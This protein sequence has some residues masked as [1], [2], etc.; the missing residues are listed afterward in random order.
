M[1]SLVEPSYEYQVG[2][3]LRVSAPSYIGRQT[4]EELYQALR[5]GEFCCVFNSRQMG[6]S[7]LRVQVKH[8]L[9]QDGVCCS[10]VDV[11]SIGSEAIAPQQWYRGLI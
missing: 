9:E 1:T 6:K 5:A 7:S 10:A 2:G 4:D 8:R 3:S 11:T